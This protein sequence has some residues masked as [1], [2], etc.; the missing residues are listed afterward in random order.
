MTA[1]I[2]DY[3][4]KDEKIDD[5]E[6]LIDHV[7]HHNYKNYN[8]PISMNPK[9]YNVLST[10]K[11]ISYIFRHFEKYN[12]VEI[13]I[14]GISVIKYT[15]HF[16]NENVFFRKIENKIFYFKTIATK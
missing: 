7:K 5:K 14:D 9:D 6:N 3:G 2:F 10:T 4:F 16:I 1:I 8:I 12:E 13:I 15:D 11:G